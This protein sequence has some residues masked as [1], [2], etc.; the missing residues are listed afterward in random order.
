M[1]LSVSVENEFS[2]KE[3]LCVYVINL[4]QTITPHGKC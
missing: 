2:F 4:M 3:T 1:L